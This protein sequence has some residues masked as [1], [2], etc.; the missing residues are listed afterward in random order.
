MLY[1]VITAHEYSHGRGKIKGIIDYYK[2]HS[3]WEID[4]NELSQPFV[5]PEHLRGWDGDGV[6]C[7]IYTPGDLDNIASLSVPCVN[8]SSSELAVNVPSVRTDNHEIGCMAASHLTECKLDHFAFVGPIGLRH[9]RE[10]YE[11]FSRSS[12]NFV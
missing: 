9:A 1:E 11:G 6:I 7:E 12:Y 10:R 3:A 2:K 4:R 5:L 8:T